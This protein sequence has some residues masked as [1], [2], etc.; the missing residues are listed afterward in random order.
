[1]KRISLVAMGL[2]GFIASANAADI[3]R[4]A[5]VYKAASAISDWT[6][7]YVGV[8]G[9]WADLTT[10]NQGAVLVPFTGPKF[11]DSGAIIGGTLGYNHQSGNFVSGF[12][13]DL[14]WLGAKA[15]EAVSCGPECSVNLQWLSTIR[16]RVGY[17]A[18]PDILLYETGGVAIGD[19]HEFQPTNLDFTETKVGWTVGGGVE[20][21]LGGG[22]S[23]KAEYL[24]VNLGATSFHPE[25][26]STQT[27]R[28]NELRNNIARIGLNYQFATR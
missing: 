4:P 9:G 21:R 28:V 23:L 18:T 16:A 14:S 8:S 20:A 5:P 19:I 3:A 22:W 6:G 7:F 17:L 25:S 1:M 15:H 12:E 2:A 26:L 13:G 24:Y 10:Q 27:T 11:K